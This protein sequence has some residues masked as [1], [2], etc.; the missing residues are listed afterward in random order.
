[1]LG[2]A[3]IGKIDFDSTG[4]SINTSTKSDLPQLLRLFALVGSGGILGNSPR[5]MIFYLE[6]RS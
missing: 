1:M 2:L 3:I 6:V 4:K 5:R